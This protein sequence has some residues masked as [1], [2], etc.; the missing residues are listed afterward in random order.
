MSNKITINCPKI[1]GFCRQL[2]KDK[3]D[4]T[5]NHWIVESPK[6]YRCFFREM[7]GDNLTSCCKVVV[8]RN[9]GEKNCVNPNHFSFSLNPLGQKLNM[10]KDDLLDLLD[11]VD[12]NRVL[13]IG[14]KNYL[15]EFNANQPDFLKISLEQLHYVVLLLVR[16]GKGL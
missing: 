5:K 14:E 3:V 10:Q 15:E 11:I 12:L 8:V 16:K 2:L 6:D 9:C 13:E 4:V 7:V 1:E